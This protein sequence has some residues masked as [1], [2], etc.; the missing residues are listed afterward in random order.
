[1]CNVDVAMEAHMDC[2]NIARDELL[3]H[4]L[5]ELNAVHWL[6]GGVLAQVDW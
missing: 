6:R 5:A 1:M 2:M 4:A 3:A